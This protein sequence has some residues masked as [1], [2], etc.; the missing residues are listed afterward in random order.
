M[1]RS[2]VPVEHV[3]AELRHPTIRVREDDPFDETNPGRICRYFFASVD[4]E[5][6]EWH[7]FLEP[8][9]HLLQNLLGTSPTTC[10]AGAFV[11]R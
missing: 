11:R 3:F 10:T 5:G 9:A 8:F 4:H 7:E 1:S 2:F 6:I